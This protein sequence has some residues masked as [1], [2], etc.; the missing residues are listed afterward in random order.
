[1]IKDQDDFIKDMTDFK[2]GWISSDY[3]IEQK[4]FE[5]QLRRKTGIRGL[6]EQKV[7]VTEKMNKEIVSIHK[8][9]A[10]KIEEQKQSIDKEP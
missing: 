6:E 7:S 9:A 8:K 5:S 10:L 2:P 1:L 4:H 3:K